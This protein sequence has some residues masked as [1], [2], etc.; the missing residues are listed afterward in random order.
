MAA[1]DVAPDVKDTSAALAQE[2]ATATSFSPSLTSGFDHKCKGR[3][4]FARLPS[5]DPVCQVVPKQTSVSH[6]SN[7]SE[8]ERLKL[9]K[10][11]HD[12][13]K[14]VKSDDAE[15]PTHLWDSFITRG[16]EVHRSNVIS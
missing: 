10:L 5:T 16:A 1:Q 13:A 6:E 14:A 11:L 15:V 8:S 4:E 7:K 12:K 3:Q 2:D 9:V